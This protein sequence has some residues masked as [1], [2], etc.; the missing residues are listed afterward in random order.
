MVAQCPACNSVCTIGKR[1][2]EVWVKS[3]AYFGYLTKEHCPACKNALKGSKWPQERPSDKPVSDSTKQENSTETGS[4]AAETT[5]KKLTD[6]QYAALQV[7]GTHQKGNEITGKDIANMIGLKP[8]S[9]GKEGAD[10]RSIINALRRKGYPICANG[11]GYYWPKETT[12]IKDYIESLE[13]RIQK[14]KEALA[15]TMMGLEEWEANPESRTPPP[16]LDLIE[17]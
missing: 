4:Q 10:M 6:L 1:D 5:D 2:K 8:R 16:P 9:T 3:I 13:G 15:G 7:I 11:S 17:V 12:E 14:E